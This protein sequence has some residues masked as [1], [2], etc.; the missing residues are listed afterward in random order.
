MG[1]LEYTFPP[2]PEDVPIVPIARLSY[3]K[4][5]SSCEN[6]TKKVLK[7]CGTDGFFYLD[8]TDGFVGQALLD[9]ADDILNVAKGALNQPLNYKIKFLAERGKEMFGYKPAGAVKKTDKDSRPDTMEFYNVAKDHLLGNSKTRDYPKEI[10]QHQEELLCFATD[11]HSLGLLILRILAEQ[12]G[13]RSDEFVERNKIS[14]LSGDH[15]RMTKMNAPS[16]LQSNTIGLPSHTDFGSVTVL[17]NWVGGLQIQSHDPEKQG[18]WAYVKPLPG[19]AIIN[20]GD[21]MV[22]FSNGRL[23]SGKHRVVPLPGAQGRLD[24]Y[25]LVYFL[26]PTD[27]VLMGPVEKYKH[28]PVVAVGGK[29]GEEKVYTAGEWMARRLKQMSK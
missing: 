29:V 27:E 24:R 19:H 10:M 8:L 22:K 5:T 18:E 2:F 26:R 1:S 9:E 7:A 12:L 20:L 17:F 23:K 28:E 25:S 21:A 13:L 16:S 4:L 3:S 14:S 6:E 15:V 11:C